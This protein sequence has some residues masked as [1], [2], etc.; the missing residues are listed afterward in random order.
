MVAMVSPT[1][2]RFAR[3]KTGKFN[4]VMRHYGPSKMVA[5]NEDGYD[6]T[7]NIKKIN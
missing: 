1:I 2:S 6:P 7:E 3:N 5:D 4:V